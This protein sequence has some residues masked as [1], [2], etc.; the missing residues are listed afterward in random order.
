MQK[1]NHYNLSPLFAPT[2]ATFVFASIVIITT[3]LAPVAFAH[4]MTM[5]SFSYLCLACCQ[6]ITCKALSNIRSC[7]EN[8]VDTQKP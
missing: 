4:E 7:V 1:V 2:C 6:Q 5:R 8:E 3:F